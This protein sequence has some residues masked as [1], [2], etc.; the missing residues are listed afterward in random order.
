MVTLFKKVS[1]SDQLKLYKTPKY[2]IKNIDKK[3]KNNPQSIIE[4]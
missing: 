3:L 1:P 4:I 2:L